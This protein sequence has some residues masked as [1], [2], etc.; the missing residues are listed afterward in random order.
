MTATIPSCSATFTNYAA[1]DFA[2][3]RLDSGS[4]TRG[5]R[6]RHVTGGGLHWTAWGTSTS[7]TAAELAM[8]QHRLST[9]TWDLW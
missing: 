7:P 3:T 5:V 6:H 4:C 8:S 9:S 1:V 2:T